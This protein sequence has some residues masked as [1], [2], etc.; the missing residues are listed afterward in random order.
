MAEL[1]V[2]HH[3]ENKEKLLL[4]TGSFGGGEVVIV[5]FLCFKPPK[6]TDEKISYK[7]PFHVGMYR[8]TRIKAHEI[9]LHL[10]HT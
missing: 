9:T 2:E 3:V 6:A 4:L 1:D 7:N 8:E 10:L 5:W